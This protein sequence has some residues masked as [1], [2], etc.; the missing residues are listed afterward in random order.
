VTKRPTADEVP[1]PAEFAAAEVVSDGGQADEGA[2][3]V[4]REVVQQLSLAFQKPV[5]RRSGTSVQAL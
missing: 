1:R 4:G 5:L 2:V 3:L